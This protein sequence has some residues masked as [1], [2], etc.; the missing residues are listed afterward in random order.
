V[1]PLVIIPTYNE[2]EN[3]GH[4]IN[5][6]FGVHPSTEILVVD[7]GSPDGTGELADDLARTDCRVHVMHRGA[8]LGLGTA[9]VAG[10]KYALAHDYDRVVEMDADFSHRPSDLPLL[11][12]ASDNADVVIGSRL[13]A[14]G[15]TE[16]W[17]LL[18]AA[19]S[20]GGSL[21]ARLM[22]SLPIRDC[23]SG[24][25]CFRRHVLETLDL[26]A[27]SSNGFGFQVEMNY[28]CSR[29]GF[30]FAEVP[31]VFPDRMAGTSKMSHGIFLEALALVG[32]LR[33]Q[34]PAG[35]ARPRHTGRSTPAAGSRAIPL[36][37][38]KA[39]GR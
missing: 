11:L 32:R 17:S 24:F 30:R 38:R 20:R 8:K 9:Y 6:I 26:D 1:K 21:Y 23:T 18:R 16:N 33:L 35:A 19:I 12:A 7:D 13:V 27:V 28:L 22:L 3:L 10:F 25:K 29:A 14:G 37:D 2:R 15:R 4:L 5:G 31:I 34:R 39:I 36:A